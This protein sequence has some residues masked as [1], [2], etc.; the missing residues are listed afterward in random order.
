MSTPTITPVQSAGSEPQP[1]GYKSWSRKRKIATWAASAILI[2]AAVTACG[3]TAAP[4]AAPRPAIT[5]TVTAAP[6]AP[7]PAKTSPAPP[8]PPVKVTISNN[9]PAAPAPAP[10]PVYVAPAP[11]PLTAPGLTNCTGGTDEAS[12]IWAGPDTS[13]PFAE[14]VAAAYS[15]G[16]GPDVEDV[17]SPVTGQSY[18][19][20]YTVEGAG[21][22]IATG[23]NNAFVQF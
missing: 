9:A 23:G 21:T 7:A 16:G 12:A 17:Y 14:N 10:A 20:T 4:S 15:G 13:C 1:H 5:H 18:V 22:V 3:S 8:V 11:V 19:M 2:A 6:K